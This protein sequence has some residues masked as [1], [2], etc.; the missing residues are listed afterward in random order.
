MIMCS[1][2]KTLENWVW[3]IWTRLKFR[4]GLHCQEPRMVWQFHHFHN[5]VV[6]RATGEHNACLLQVLT[7]IVIYLKAMTM[8]LIYQRLTVNPLCQSTRHY[9]AWVSA[10]THGAA[11]LHYFLLLR[12]NVDDM[13]GALWVQFGRICIGKPQ[14]MAAVLNHCQLHT[15]QMPRNGTLFSRQ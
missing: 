3:T 5:M 7:I 6:R 2:Y 12:H 10:Q 15:R 11:Q 4:M 13:V 1:F 9:L 14:Y 8:A